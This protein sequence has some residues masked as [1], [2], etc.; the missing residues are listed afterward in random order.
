MARRRRA[1]RVAEE[2]AAEA[3]Y[4]AMV[5]KMPRDMQDSAASSLP[6]SLRAQFG[7]GEAP[8]AGCRCLIANHECCAAASL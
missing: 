5:A 2:E 6:G 4:K 8:I 3:R 1:Q 7:D